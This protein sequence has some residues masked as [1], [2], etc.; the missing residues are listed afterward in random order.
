[1]TAAAPPAAAAEP[2]APVSCGAIP[3]SLDPLQCGWALLD[4]ATRGDWAAI[5]STAAA[6]ALGLLLPPFSRE[7][8]IWFA[9]ACLPPLIWFAGTL[10]LGRNSGDFSHLTFYFT[11]SF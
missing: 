2:G 8:R 3:S 4:L 1:L 11:F 7:E 5:E 6:L 9:G 10:H